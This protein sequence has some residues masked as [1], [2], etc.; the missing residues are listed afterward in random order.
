MGPGYLNPELEAEFVAQNHLGPR[1]YNGYD[2]GGYLIWRLSPQCQVMMDS[3]AFPY[4]SWF[5]DFLAFSQGL[6]FEALTQR[7]PADV[8]VI[9]WR[10]RALLRQ[11]SAQPE[12]W[13]A[14]YTGPSAAVFQR[15]RLPAPALKPSLPPGYSRFSQLQSPQQ[16]LL[17]FSGLLDLGDVEAADEA[18]RCCQQ[19]L[20]TPPDSR[21]LPAL[22]LHMR[23]LRQV[24]R[25]DYA[26]AL[27]TLEEGE[28]LQVYVN[29]SLLEALRQWR[30]KNPLP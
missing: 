6:Q 12:V 25:K 24:Q 8:A 18:L 17:V 5:A 27:I 11:F 3:R 15:T 10:D 19:N 20:L 9:S 13:R 23:G 26:D 4:R 2:N 29:H 7:Y 30:Q 16:G 28:R 21:I 1:L 14:V 22:E